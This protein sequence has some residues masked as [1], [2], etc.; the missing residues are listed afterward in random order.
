[1]ERIDARTLSDQQR[2]LLRKQVIS[3]RK[4]GYKNKEISVIT[5]L[6]EAT[7]SRYWTWYQQDGAKMLKVPKR[8]R[9]EGEKRTLTPEQE[10]EIRKLITDK[11][12][13]Q[14]KL[15]F[16]LWDRKAVIMLIK[17]RY[18]IKMPIRTAGEYL[19]RW[20]FTPQ[21]PIKRAYEQRPAEVKVWMED[22]YPEIKAKAKI[23]NAE[24]YWGDE[25]GIETSGNRVRGY[26][27]AGKTPEIKLNSR[28]EHVSMISAVSNQGK[29]RFMMY[30]GAMDGA[31]LIE[32][33]KRLTKSAK[34]K[35]ILILDNLRVHHCKPVKAWLAENKNLIEVF[36]LPAYSPE[37][38]PDEYLNSDLKSVV[39]GNAGSISRSINEIR[40]K[41]FYHMKGLQKNEMKVRK[42][43]HHP[44][45]K[46]AADY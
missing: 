37:L 1:M 35:V 18:G 9:K 45:V 30:E 29:L 27:P 3:L 14:L 32:F 16:V 25:T 12:P 13:D 6:P 4:K 21:R 17:N 38:N 20:G 26:A 36:Y 34:R 31:R 5:G 43:F 2:E 8:G 19:A 42:F 23:E 22:E 28:K 15:P 24:I 7:C 39:H 41:V 46:Y 33:M 44:K 40:G 11:C 10:H